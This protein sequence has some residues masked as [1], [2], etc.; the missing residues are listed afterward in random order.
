[1]NKLI[2]SLLF[3][4]SSFICHSQ[5]KY[6]EC[7]TMVVIKDGKTYVSRTEV[8]MTLT[9]SQDKKFLNLENLV[10]DQ[11]IRLE[12]LEELISLTPDENIRLYNIRNRDRHD[13]TGVISFLIVN[14]LLHSIG[15]SAKTNIL[16]IFQVKK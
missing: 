3:F 14:D 4:L 7:D 12:I 11:E 2:I 1:M 9:K 13:D 8:L 10:L 6:W 16:I 15:I 5:T